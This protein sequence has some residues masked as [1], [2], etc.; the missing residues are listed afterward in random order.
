MGVDK[1]EIPGL[2]RIER[3]WYRGIGLHHAGLLPAVRRVTEL[4]LERRTLRVVYATETFAVGV[5][6]P[7]RSVC[8]DSM[9]KFD[10]RSYRRLT[11]NEYFQMAGRAGRRGLDRRGV[12]IR[13]APLFKAA[14]RAAAPVGRGRPAR[15]PEFVF[16]YLQ[17]GDQPDPPV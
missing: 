8:F 4:L 5:N 16:P 9:E 6:M 7:V 3:L 1:E 14:Q 2:D 15:G 17:H 11:A 13:L 12:V 10:G